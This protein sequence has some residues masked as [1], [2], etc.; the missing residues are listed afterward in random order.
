VQ[1]SAGWCRGDALSSDRATADPRYAWLSFALPA[2]AR[3]FRTEDSELTALLVEAGAEPKTSGP[4]VEIAQPGGLRGDARAAAVPIYRSRVRAGG[5][6]GRALGRVAGGVAL[7][8]GLRRAVRAARRLGYGVTR[9]ITWER[10]VPVRAP[11]IPKAVSSRPA[12]RFPLNGVVVAQREGT[13][14]TIF[15]EVLRAA[16][17]ATGD[18]SSPSRVVF[19]SSGVVVADLGAAVLRVAVGASGARIAAQREVVGRLL[20]GKPSNELS[21]K[22]PRILAGGCEGLATWALE[23]HLVGAHSARL[24]GP[25]A[26]EAVRFLVE[27]S[28]LP[29]DG[30]P[31]AR[32]SA[33]AGTVAAGC[34]ERIAEQVLEIAADASLRLAATPPCFVHGDFWHGN[35][36]GEAGRLTGVIDWSAGGPDGLPMLDAL[37]LQLSSLREE[38]SE[39]FGVAVTRR[40]LAIELDE[41]ALLRAYK[42]HLGLVLEADEERALVAAYW[43]DALARDLRDPDAPRHDPAAWQDDNVLPVL[44]AGVGL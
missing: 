31:G 5:S 11:G 17:E 6:V 7:A 40:L 34:S 1:S 27:L 19:G 21:A 9:T 10:S 14:R 39:P 35:L 15:D 44:Q 36:L 37:H 30:S 33:A 20:G 24:D 2:D 23:A 16:N 4:D 42:E 38:T 25:L 43:L 22:V 8:L 13:S 32:L 12:H 41:Y 26:E 29:A 3:S 28:R 18:R